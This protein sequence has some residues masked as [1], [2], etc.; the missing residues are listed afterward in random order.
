[1]EPT[2]KSLATIPQGDLSGDPTAISAGQGEVRLG[3]VNPSLRLTNNLD[4]VSTIEH[5][6][7]IKPIAPGGRKTAG[8]SGI[9]VLFGE[10]QPAPPQGMIMWRVGGRVMFARQL[11]YPARHPVQNAIDDARDW[12]HSQTRGKA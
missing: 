1:M 8:R 7:I 6:G 10:R 4:F 2:I 9:G 12:Y 5:G 11:D 3:T